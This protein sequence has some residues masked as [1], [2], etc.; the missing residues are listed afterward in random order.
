[1]SLL[2]LVLLPL[3]GIWTTLKGLCWI[4]TVPIR[5]FLVFL[6]A[7]PS[8]TRRFSETNNNYGCLVFAGVPWSIV[9]IIANSFVS[10]SP[11]WRLG[12]QDYEYIWLALLGT[13]VFSGLY[14]IGRWS[15]NQNKENKTENLI[16]EKK[17]EPSPAP[18]QEK[19]TYASF[20]EMYERF[21]DAEINSKD[22]VKKFETEI[23]D[24]LKRDRIALN[25]AC[26]L[27]AVVDHG[28]RQ[29]LGMS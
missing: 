6:I 2:S 12:Y 28:Y 24:A 25:E 19:P 3:V 14:E 7:M 1:M 8:I 9:I 10:L 5:N 26:K 29:I 23:T 21:S 17:P 13:N 27:K 18:K 20:V 16:T 15:N 4:I 11:E 22:Q